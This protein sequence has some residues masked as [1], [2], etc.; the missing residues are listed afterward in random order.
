MWNG[1]GCGS[2]FKTP[3][4]PRGV[5]IWLKSSSLTISMFD[6][7]NDCAGWFCFCFLVVWFWLTLIIAFPPFLEQTHL[8][9][10]T[11]F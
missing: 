11:L 2:V 8:N 6:F 10:Y 7:K 4:C 9:R 1:E 3:Q 5:E